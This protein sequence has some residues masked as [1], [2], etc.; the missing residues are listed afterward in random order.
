M[1]QPEPAPDLDTCI[2][3]VVPPLQQLLLALQAEWPEATT[4]PPRLFGPAMAATRA[5]LAVAGHPTMAPHLAR[6]WRRYG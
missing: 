4:M 2:W 5:L 1:G 3:G 6:V